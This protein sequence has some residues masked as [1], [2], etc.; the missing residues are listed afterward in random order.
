M[1]YA[2][3]GS[4]G[5]RK[6][7]LKKSGK[8]N[9]TGWDMHLYILYL[10][11]LEIIGKYVLN[12]WL[13]LWFFLTI[14]QLL[15]ASPKP[16]ENNL[17]GGCNAKSSNSV[18]CLVFPRNTWRMFVHGVGLCDCNYRYPNIFLILIPKTYTQT[19]LTPCF[20][21][22]LVPQLH[23]ISS[24]IG[25]AISA[26]ARAR[27]WRKRSGSCP[28]IRDTEQ[29]TGPSFGAGKKPSGIPWCSTAKILLLDSVE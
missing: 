19:L 15:A 6:I 17:F 1:L 11:I 28:A 10:I 12:T 14:D 9:K 2:V 8:T 5:S 22:I 25:T 27:S 18:V 16:A 20:S 26:L 3:N 4:H 7:I 24:H 29:A 13:V 23:S 21:Q